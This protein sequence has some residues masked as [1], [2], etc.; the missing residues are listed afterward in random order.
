MTPSPNG[1]A[2]PAAPV[3]PRAPDPATQAEHWLRAL[4]RRYRWIVGAAMVCASGAAWA[5]P[6]LVQYGADQQAER[7]ERAATREDVD[8]LKS[9][10]GELRKDVQ[11]LRS[12]VQRVL[13]RQL[14]PVAP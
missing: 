12:D 8:E 9:D 7:D 6:R 13:A 10:V 1:S 11:G 14:G 5:V 2:G 3:T 4:W